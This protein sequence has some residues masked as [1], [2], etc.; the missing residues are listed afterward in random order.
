M[1]AIFLEVR[2]ALHRRDENAFDTYGLVCKRDDEREVGANN[3]IKLIDY[4]K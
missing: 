3:I 2:H 4:I 1:F